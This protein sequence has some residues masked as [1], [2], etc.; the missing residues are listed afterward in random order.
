MSVGQSAHPV[1]FTSADYKWV[2]SDGASD[3]DI[4]GAT[5]STYTL[6]AADEGRTVK[7]RVS[8]TDDVGN[9]ESLTSTAT[10]EV[11]FAVQPQTA[12]SPATWAEP[13]ITGTA[14]V[15]ETPN[16]EHLG[17]RRC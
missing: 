4:T 13:A 1:Q 6:A 14:R 2:A 5:D 7:V 17:D 12:N 8:F 11:G 9:D 3:T 10:D 16:G 15:G